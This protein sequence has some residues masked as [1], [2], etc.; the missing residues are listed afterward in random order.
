[1]EKNNQQLYNDAI[2]TIAELLES[3]EKGEGEKSFYSVLMHFKADEKWGIPISPKDKHALQ[4]TADI[5]KIKAGFDLAL[6]D[7][8]KRARW[9]AMI[10]LTLHLYIVDGGKNPLEMAEKFTADGIVVL[11]FQLSEQVKAGGEQ[12]VVFCD[13]SIVERSVFDITTYVLEELE[14]KYPGYR[15]NLEVKY[16]KDRADGLHNDKKDD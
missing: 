9:F 10:S 8:E 11:P 15:D 1:M 4:A 3:E 13:P 14:K 12:P 16:F 7:S 5:N 6:F 2:D